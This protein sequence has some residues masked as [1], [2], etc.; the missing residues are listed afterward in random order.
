MESF[1]Q[2][3][4]VFAPFNNFDD[5]IYFPSSECVEF[6]VELIPADKIDHLK[7]TSSVAGNYFDLRSKNEHIKLVQKTL[8]YLNEGAAEKVVIS[9][10]EDIVKKDM[11]IVQ[12]FDKMLSMYQNAYVYLWS[13]PKIGMWMGASP[14]RLLT[15]KKSHFSTVALAGTKSNT[16]SNT[17]WGQKEKQ[18]QKYVTDYILNKLKPLVKSIETNGPN[19][20]KAGSLLHLK[21]VISGELIKDNSLKQIIEVLHPTPAVCG[22]PKKTAFE[23]IL[24]NETYSRTFYTG[25]LGEINCNKKSELFVNLR[26]MEI[27]NDQVS[28]YVGGG[29][30][31]ESIPENEWKETVEKTCIMKRVLE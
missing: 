9:R 28:I 20:I 22:I 13:H 5:T 31:K 16:E 4:F 1:E 25:Y 24:K 8:D 11:D 18:E 2:Q 21:T 17:N 29:I 30:T 23:F 6:S 26:C 10:K 27:E 3:G 19:T 15:I 7:K 12:L 14:E